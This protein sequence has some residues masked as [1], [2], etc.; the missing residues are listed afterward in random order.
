[1]KTKFT[2]IPI[3]FL[4]LGFFFVSA[5]GSSAS[6]NDL[7]GGQ[8]SSLFLIDSNNRNSEIYNDISSFR[9]FLK[10]EQK[11]LMPPGAESLI[12]F[13]DTIENSNIETVFLS[14]HQFTRSWGGEDTE[15]SFIVNLV[16]KIST[17]RQDYFFSLSFNCIYSKEVK[18]DGSV[19]EKLNCKKAVF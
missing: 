3:L 11:R 12:K 18:S 7:S 5:Y 13:P 4:W 2:L 10:E 1:M 8:S 14:G 15:Q 6:D 19:L 16:G 9:T 17:Y